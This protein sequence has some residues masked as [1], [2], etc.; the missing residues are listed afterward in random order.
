[1]KKESGG[2]PKNGLLFPFAE[3]RL[4]LLRYFWLPRNMKDS[5]RRGRLA[6]ETSAACANCKEDCTGVSCC[7]ESPQLLLLGM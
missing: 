4:S 7:W 5:N 6:G 1:M 2:P 3:A